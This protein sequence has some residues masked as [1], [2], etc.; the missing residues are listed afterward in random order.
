MIGLVGFSGSGKSTLVNVLS[1]LLPHDKGNIFIDDTVLTRANTPGWLENIGYV[2]QSPFI[3]DATLAENVALS[4]WGEEIDR[5]RVLKCC[6]MAALDF[7][8]DLEGGIDTVLGDRGV[9]L[10]GGEAQRVAIARSLYSD[11]GLIIFDEA[12]SA[13]DMK[14]EQAIHHT[15]LSL[16]NQVTMIIIA[17]RLTTVEN[18]DY[19]IWLDKGRIKMQGS[20]AEVLPSYKIA[21]DAENINS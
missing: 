4:R 10:S 2:S 3:L 9:R 12:T 6:E 19:L 17:H 11:P 18:C 1:G 15:V 8:D 14:N 13:L 5:A 7:I 21:L 20:V 16:H